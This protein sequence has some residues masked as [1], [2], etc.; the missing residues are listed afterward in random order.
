MLRVLEDGGLNDRDKHQ[1]VVKAIET[2]SEFAP[3]YLILGDLQRNENKTAA[4]IETY[5][6]GVSK[7][8]EPHV[9]TRLQIALAGL[10]PE[11]AAERKTLIAS[12]LSQKGDLIAQ[13]TAVL[14]QKREGA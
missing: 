10:L 1:M 14:L 2:D 6:A 11:G 13:A 8:V 5:R 9:E 12:V 3:F 4:A 7:A